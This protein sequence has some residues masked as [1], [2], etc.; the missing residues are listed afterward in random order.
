MGITIGMKWIRMKKV[1]Q[2]IIIYGMITINKNIIKIQWFLLCISV[3][4][5]IIKKYGK[6]IKTGD[7]IDMYVDMDK[8]T[9]QFSINGRDYGIAH[10]DIK[11]TPSA[12]G[13]ITY[14]LA[15]SLTG[16]G[17]SVRIMYYGDY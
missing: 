8:R 17:S 3:S 9:M 12:M 2:I 5:H 15:I 4:I 7:I 13:K 14:K 6:E 1:F 16:V 10:K 11:Q